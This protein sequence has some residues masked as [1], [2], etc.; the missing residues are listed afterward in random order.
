MKEWKKK[1]D[2]GKNGE[3]EAEERKGGRMQG[4]KKEKGNIVIKEEK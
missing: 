2:E 4:K 3:A 1:R